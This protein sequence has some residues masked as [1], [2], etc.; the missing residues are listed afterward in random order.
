M[1]S[2]LRLM[3]NS[4]SCVPNRVTQMSVFLFALTKSLR[5]GPPQGTV[6]EGD[7]HASLFSSPPTKLVPSQ[8]QASGGL[9]GCGLQPSSRGVLGGEGG[10]GTETVQ[11]SQ[12]GEIPSR[13][14]LAWAQ[15]ESLPVMLLPNETVGG[16]GGEVVQR[17]PLLPPLLSCPPWLGKHWAEVSWLPLW[18]L[19]RKEEALSA[20]QFISWLSCAGAPPFSGDG[21]HPRD[22]QPG[23]LVVR[24][25]R[26]KRPL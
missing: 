12:L 13:A 18:L 6:W 16:G 4:E 22:S 25:S 14:F 8:G 21:C 9:K 1:I 7:G 2:L 10:R 17:L 5:E 24:E 15:P 23:L 11:S 20:D 26:I 3:H 19:P